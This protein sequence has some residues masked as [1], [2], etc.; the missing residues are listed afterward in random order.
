VNPFLRSGAGAL[1]AVEPT[2]SFSAHGGTPARLSLTVSGAT[3]RGLHE[4]TGGVTVPQS[5]AI[6]F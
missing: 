1:P 5:A 6:G 3:P 4:I 2:P